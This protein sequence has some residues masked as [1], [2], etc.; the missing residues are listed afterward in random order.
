M[1][2]YW[3]NVDGLAA[4]MIDFLGELRPANGVAA[5]METTES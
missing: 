4:S 2:F 3:W 1:P 5:K